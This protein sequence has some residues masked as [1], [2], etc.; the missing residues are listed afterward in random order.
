MVPDGACPALD[1]EEYRHRPR[2]AC[3]RPDRGTAIHD[4]PEIPV[5]AGI[6]NRLLLCLRPPGGIQVYY[7][8]SLFFNGVN[9]VLT[10]IF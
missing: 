1:A 3:P 9:I 8:L 6:N 7:R 2:E 4:K 10:L 5:F